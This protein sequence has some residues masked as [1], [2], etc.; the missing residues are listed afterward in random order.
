M[1]ETAAG[2][3]GEVCRLLREVHGGSGDVSRCEED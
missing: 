1:A 2:L 3:Q